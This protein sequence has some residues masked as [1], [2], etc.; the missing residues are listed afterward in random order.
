M[1]SVYKKNERW[2]VHYKDGDGRW[3]DLATNADAKADAKRMLRD[4]EQKSERVLQGLEIGHE[5]GGT[6]AELFE[7][8][9]ENYSK[10]SPSHQRNVYAVNK[11]FIGGEL[12]SI[13]LGSLRAGHVETFLQK[14]TKTLSPE[15]V[16]HLRRFLLGAINAAKRAGRFHGPN[17]V[18]DVRQRKVPKR[19]PDYLRHDEVPRV[20]AALDPRFRPL[21]A[22]AIYTGLR[23]GELFAL[24]KTDVDFANKLLT[25]SGSHG[26]DVA[27]GGRIDVIPIADA[28]VPFLKKAV[29]TSPSDLVFPAP[30]GERRR[31]D[32]KLM[33]ILRGALGRADITL[34][35]NQVCRRSGCGHAEQTKTR[36]E[37]R[38]PKCNMKLWPKAIV[39]P[40]RFHDMRHT[41]ASLLMMSGVNPAAVQR[42]MRHSNPKLTTEVYGHL[43][44]GYLRDEVNRLQFDFGSVANENEAL[45]AP[46]SAQNFDVLAANLLLGSENGENAAA[47]QFSIPF[48]FAQLDV[49]RPSGIE[50][51]TP[52]LE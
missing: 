32:Q 42:I 37:K 1:G 31:E 2:Y 19:K 7:W 38:C 15:T 11:H 17:P 35:Y 13:T 9:L 10:G 51:L 30:D 28:L 39:R 48:D 29:D 47:E 24:K 45:Q 52:G 50:P 49:A 23:K 8:W 3:R 41:T 21:F 34:G 43:A 36:E 6:V 25:V 5:E 46:A 18:A 22:T 4:L 26:R 27:K 44:P 12:A 20:L 14:K 33:K 40:I 16:N